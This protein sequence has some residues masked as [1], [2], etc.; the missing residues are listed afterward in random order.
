MRAID[1]QAN[2]FLLTHWKTDSSWYDPRLHNATFVILPA[3][4]WASLR[5][6][7]GAVG[8]PAKTYHLGAGDQGDVVG[9]APQPSGLRGH[10]VPGVLAGGADPVGEA[11]QVRIEGGQRGVQL[12]GGVVEQPPP[13]GRASAGET[14]PR[15]MRARS[16]ARAHPVA[17]AAYG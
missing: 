12:V 11:L 16:Y 14:V 15:A 8:T 2:E 17:D 3:D 1:I 4:A 9:Q 10:D 13:G 7:Y 6:V 5:N